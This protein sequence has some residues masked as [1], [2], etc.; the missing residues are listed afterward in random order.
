MHMNEVDYCFIWE[1]DYFS[2]IGLVAIQVFAR[3]QEFDTLNV[4]E[5]C[6]GETVDRASGWRSFMLVSCI[7]DWGGGGSYRMIYLS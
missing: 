6:H 2:N 3:E 4:L 5:N 7:F 1:D